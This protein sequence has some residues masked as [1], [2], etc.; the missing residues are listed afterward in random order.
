MVDSPD[1]IGTERTAMAEAIV[2]LKA[3]TL[4]QVLDGSLAMGDA[5]AFARAAGMMAAKKAFEIIPLRPALPLSAVSVTCEPDET[6]NLIRV[7]ATVRASG[8]RSV[9]TEALTAASVAALALCDVLLPAERDM[10]IETVRL[11]SRQTSLS[12]GTRKEDQPT[13]HVALRRASA[14]QIKARRSRP[15]ATVKDSGPDPVQRKS[16]ADS[17]GKRDALRRFMQARGLTAHAWARDAGMPV[18]ILY[19]YLH[20][21]TH[22]LSRAEEERLA[23]AV[24]VD[25]DDLYRV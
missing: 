24:N 16:A 8:D 7:L 15:P 19:S 11:V 20:G 10:I 9:E 3:A 23:S 5:L 17:A 1:R 21:R 12:S 4:A 6:E 22:A 18:G 14:V 13:R 2:R 25:P